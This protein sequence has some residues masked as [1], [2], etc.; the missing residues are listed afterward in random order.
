VGSYGPSK[1]TPTPPS[2]NQLW[3]VKTNPHSSTVWREKLNEVGEKDGAR[4]STRWRPSAAHGENL[5]FF[6]YFIFLNWGN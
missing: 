2:S 6:I 1:Q 3:P 5:F 4:V